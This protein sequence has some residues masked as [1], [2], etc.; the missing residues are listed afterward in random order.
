MGFLYWWEA[1]EAHSSSDAW[2]SHFNGFACCRAWALGL[3]GSI[4]AAHGLQSADSVADA[5]P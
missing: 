1:G 5:Q 3:K 4:V 2:A